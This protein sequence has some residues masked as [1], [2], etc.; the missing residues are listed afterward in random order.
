MNSVFDTIIAAVNSGKCDIII[1]AQNITAARKKQVDM[2]TYFQAGQSFVDI[3]VVPV[4]DRRTSI[5]KSVVVT[6]SSS[7]IYNLATDPAA[8]VATGFI[9]DSN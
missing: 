1:S 8:R 2:I 7:R 3:I 5:A 9:A 4:N 6:L